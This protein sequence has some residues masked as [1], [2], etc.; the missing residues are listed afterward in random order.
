M[1]GSKIAPAQHFGDKYIRTNLHPQKNTARNSKR[2]EQQ[3]ERQCCWF[4]KTRILLN[5]SQC[6]DGTLS[7]YSKVGQMVH[8][9]IQ[10]YS[11]I[12]RDYGLFKTLFIDYFNKFQSKFKFCIVFLFIVYC[13][14]I[15][16]QITFSQ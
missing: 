13:V 5:Q 2:S 1:P 4:N 11:F 9:E 16:S 3:K 12:C 15:W 10:L 8:S 6:N 7:V 14:S